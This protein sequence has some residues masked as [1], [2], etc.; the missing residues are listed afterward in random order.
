M[1]LIA[2]SMKS[3]K[4]VAPLSDRVASARSYF[5]VAAAAAAGKPEVQEFMAWLE[6]EARDQG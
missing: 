1:P 2:G 5:M 6:A 4:L 3:R